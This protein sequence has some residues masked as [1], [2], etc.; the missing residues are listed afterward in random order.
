MAFTTRFD[1]I[2]PLRAFSI[3]ITNESYDFDRLKS[4]K[5]SNLDTKSWLRSK[6]TRFEGSTA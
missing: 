6:A 5:F 2:A 3:Y 4:I 1:T